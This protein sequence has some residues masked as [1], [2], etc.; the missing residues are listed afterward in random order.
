LPGGRLGAHNV[1]TYSLTG[2][3]VNV[4]LRIAGD[5]RQ[6]L[7]EVGE[8]GPRVSV[9]EQVGEEVSSNSSPSDGAG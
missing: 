8:H 9:C 7:V 4:T 6:H 5:H 3:K 2:P 1:V